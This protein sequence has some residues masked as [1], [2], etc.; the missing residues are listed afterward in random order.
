MLRDCL[1]DQS[2][3]SWVQPVL[4]MTRASLDDNSAWADANVLICTQHTLVQTLE[5]WR[6]QRGSCRQQAVEAALDKLQEASWI[7]QAEARRARRR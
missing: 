1:R 7:Q 3:G 2:A 5:R 6:P 4:C